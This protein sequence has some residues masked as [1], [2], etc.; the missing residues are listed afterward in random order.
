VCL[1]PQSLSNIHLKEG[2]PGLVMQVIE[3]IVPS[4]AKVFIKN[5][6]LDKMGITDYHWHT[7]VSDLPEEAIVRA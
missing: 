1:L 7:S 6:L 4:T 2:D 5:E 3:A